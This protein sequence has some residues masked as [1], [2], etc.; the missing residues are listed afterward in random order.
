MYSIQ[1][2]LAMLTACGFA[3]LIPL[4][5]LTTHWILTLIIPLT[6]KLPS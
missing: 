5:M 6:E 2:R 4:G 3:A 1:K